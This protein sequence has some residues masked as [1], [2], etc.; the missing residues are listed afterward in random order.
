LTLS[1]R[2]ESVIWDFNGTIV[3]DLSL[4]LRSVN[5]QLAERGLPLLTL[6]RYRDVFG[7]PVE[8]YYREIGLDLDVESM[9]GLSAEF[10]RLYAPGLAACPLHEGVCAALECY[11]SNGSRQFVLSAMEERLLLRTVEQLGILEFFDAVYGLAHLEA[12]SKV[13][14]GRDLLA[15]FGIRPEGALLIGDTDHDAEVAAALGT[16]VVLVATGHQS[17]ARL[18]A[19]GSVVVERVEHLCVS[20]SG[21]TGRGPRQGPPDAEP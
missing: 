17:A 6:D 20:A 4:V 3:D 7:F 21:R 19:T 9:A 12:D 2:I 5:A 11:R 14:R 18:R 1:R 13:S 8:G 16:P 15:D 10:F